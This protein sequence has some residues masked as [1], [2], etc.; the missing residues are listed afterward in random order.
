MYKMVQCMTHKL[1]LNLVKKLIFIVITEILCKAPGK[2]KNGKFTNSWRGVFEFNEGV[3]YSCNPS[4]GPQA[5]S[6]VGENRLTCSGP[7]KWSSDPPECKVVRCRPPE[8]KH[9]KPVSEMKG[10]FFYKEEFL[11][12]CLEGFY[13]NSS[14]PVFCGGNS[15]WEP[16]KPA[17]IKG[18]TSAS[19]KSPFSGYLGYSKLRQITSLDDIVELEPGTIAL[20]IIIIFVGI[21]VT[22]TCVY[23]CLHGGKKGMKASTCLHYKKL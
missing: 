14:N 8:L 18:F 21:A 9:G 16:E 15:T 7:G 22:C 10:T 4:H 19:T 17:C 1:A 13:L 2:I 3:T 12:E 11:F 5:Y 23:K 6:L 20:I